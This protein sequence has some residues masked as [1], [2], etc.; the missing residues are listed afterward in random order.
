MILF[1][2][3]ITSCFCSIGT[4]VFCSSL[5]IIFMSSFWGIFV[6][7]FVMSEPSFMFPCTLV[8]FSLNSVR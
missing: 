2:R 5:S 1:V 3:H 8:Y 7:V 6:Y 4:L